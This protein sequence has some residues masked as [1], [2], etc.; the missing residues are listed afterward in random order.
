MNLTP[1]STGSM[2]DTENTSDDDT[3]RDETQKV[4][5]SELY[6]ILLLPI[7]ASFGIVS[8][9]EMAAIKVK[10]MT[11]KERQ[12]IRGNVSVLFAVR[13]PGCGGC[14]EHA[15]QLAELASKD[16]KVSLAGAVKETGVDDQ[17][18]LDFYSQ[19]FQHPIYKD[20][21]W[22]IFHAMGGKKIS[23]FSLIKRAAFLYKRTK[24]KGIES[25]V[26]HGDI[27][28]KGGVLVFNRAGEL[29]YTQY[30]HFGREFDMQA[31]EQAIQSIRR[32][33]KELK[34]NSKSVP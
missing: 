11:I 22:K 14:R 12:K 9:N 2:A 15:V 20:E 25:K 31:I 26:R 13:T 4:K 27:W 1:S 7:D 23:V 5:T 29:K 19:Y 24:S 18:L 33:D 3:V 16:K 30:E 32:E 34:R 17:A 10:P 28:T 21:K 8:V 6:E